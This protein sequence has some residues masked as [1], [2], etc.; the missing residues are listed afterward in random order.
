M[1]EGTDKFESFCEIYECAK[2]VNKHANE[3]DFCLFLR[4][5]ITVIEKNIRSR[6][7]YTTAFTIYYRCNAQ[8]WR[9]VTCILKKDY[10]SVRLKK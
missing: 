7:I 9:I 1:E 3:L 5:V 4:K 10:I 2:V 6:S 8:C